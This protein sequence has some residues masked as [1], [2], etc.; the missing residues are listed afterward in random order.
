VDDA[1]TPDSDGPPWYCTMYYYIP[2]YID[3]PH[4]YYSSVVGRHYRAP[5]ESSAGLAP[6][7]LDPYG[8][9]PRTEQEVPDASP[10]LTHP[11]LLEAAPEGRSDA[12]PNAARS[13]KFV[14]SGSLV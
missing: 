10:P 11:A 5:S 12:I 3:T 14:F 9:P 6:C 8:R 2:M 7:G 1:T 13:A 4:P